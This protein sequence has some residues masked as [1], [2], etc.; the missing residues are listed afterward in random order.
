MQRLADG[1]PINVV[2]QGA[3]AAVQFCHGLPDA[4]TTWRHEV[5]P[6]DDAGYCAVTLDMPDEMAL[7]V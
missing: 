3:G 6:I 1:H 4:S 2:K 7:T 5:Q